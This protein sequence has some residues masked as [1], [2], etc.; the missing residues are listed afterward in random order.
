MRV[1]LKNNSKVLYILMLIIILGL[2]G[3]TYAVASGNIN[4]SISTGTYNVVYSGTA[5]L[6]SATLQPVI[7]DELLN[8]DNKDKIIK[9]DFTVKGAESNPTNKNIIYDVSLT[10]LNLEEG[11][12]HRLLK[13]RLY[14][15]NALL[16]EGNFSKDFDTQANNRMVLTETQQDLPSYSNAADSYT[17]YIWI[18]EECAGDITLCTEEMDVSSLLNKTLSG[19]IR[20]EL[21]TGSKKTISR[22]TGEAGSTLANL[23]NTTNIQIKEGPDFSNISPVVST[24]KESEGIS[25]SSNINQT[26][27]TYYVTYAE[28]YEFNKET[29]KYSLVNA[30]VAKYSD[31][32]TE[33]EGKYIVSPTLSTS[34]TIATYTNRDTIYYVVSATYDGTVS[35]GVIE[36]NSNTSKADEIDESDTGI[37]ST[38]DDLG[39]SYY[40]RGN[41]T[42]NYV[43]FAGFYWRIIR[44]NGDGTVRM[45]YDGTSAHANGE[46][47][48]DR[49][50]GVVRFKAV[51]VNDNT[52]VGYMYGI[53]DATTYKETHSNLYDSTIKEY[54]E[55]T[56]YKENILDKGYDNYVADAIYCN[57]RSLNTSKYTG[58]GKNNTYYYFETRS[59][60]TLKCAQINDRFTVSDELGNGKNKYPIGLITA[61]EVVF[62]GG[63]AT[64][65]NNIYYLYTGYS[66]WT[67]T[68]RAYMTSYSVASIWYNRD[69]GGLHSNGPQVSHGGKPVISLKKDAI[70]GGTGTMIDPYVVE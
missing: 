4:L 68:P 42:N 58:I 65:V 69:D 44:I 59:P 46:V 17:F 67:M 10:N 12:H 32:Y 16:Y 55:N 37:F 8:S 28:S 19:E 7:D 52:Y 14:K 30:Q 53:E 22:L 49:T 5:T 45:I 47:S 21:S 54:L 35:I 34:S 51:P 40:Y 57:D 6:P 23:N 18:S 25:G 27:K 24:Y 1:F 43:Y 20:I 61:D 3:I 31:V 41:I 39:I 60:V 15:N 36:Y 11:L 29:G 62:A 64:T 56:W 48:Q 2:I 38:E 26:S 13:W 63:G 66:Y 50:L 9:I 70:I 33:L